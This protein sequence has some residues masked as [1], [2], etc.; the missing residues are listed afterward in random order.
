M[1]E[2]MVKVVYSITGQNLL[3]KYKTKVIYL[4]KSD[5][6]FFSEYTQ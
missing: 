4:V 5:F 2:F 6:F 3:G 1:T